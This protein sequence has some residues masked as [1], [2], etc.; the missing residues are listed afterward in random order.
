MSYQTDTD[1]A[2]SFP[3]ILDIPKMS[4]CFSMIESQNQDQ[5]FYSNVTF[6]EMIKRSPPAINILQSCSYRNFTQNSMYHQMNSEMCANIFQITRYKM[7]S[8]LCYRFE[9]DSPSQY[10]YHT[11]VNSLYS[12]R[13]LFTMTINSPL[14]GAKVIYPILHVNSYP[15]ADRAFNRQAFHNENARYY[16]SYSL[17]ESVS[18]PLPYETACID[19]SPLSCF[20]QCIDFSY[21]PRGFMSDS[22]LVLEDTDDSNL[23]LIS[24]NS[25]LDMQSNINRCYKQC[26]FNACK[27]KLVITH[28]SVP[29]QS[30]EKLSFSIQITDQLTQRN[31][32]V[33]K[34]SL[35]DYLTQM[36]GLVG[37]WT[38]ISFTSMIQVITYQS[39]MN[40]FTEIKRKVDD[41]ASKMKQ[42]LKKINSRGG[43]FVEGKS[44]QQRP[45]KVK[46]CNRCKG[47]ITLFFT[48]L[49]IIILSLFLWQMN[50]TLSNYFLY[51]T[52]VTFHYEMNPRVKMI[53][54][55]LCF[56][57][58]DIFN[59]TSNSDVAEKNYEDHFTLINSKSN[60]TLGQM[61]DQLDAVKMIGGCYIRDW[62]S[63]FKEM[64]FKQSTE[65][66][67]HII[68]KKV[69]FSQNVCVSIIPLVSTGKHYQLDYRLLS[70]SPGV[71]ISIDVNVYFAHSNIITFAFFGSGKPTWATEHST[72]IKSDENRQV[73]I[74]TRLHE[75]NILPAP[76]DTHCNKS[77]SMSKCYTSCVD[78]MSEKQ[79]KIAL[80]S[81][82]DQHVNM[83]TLTF[84]D[85][86]NETFYS[87]WTHLERGCNKKCQS[88]SCKYN[89]VTTEL[90]A[91]NP[92]EKHNLL[93]SLETPSYPSSIMRAQ[94]VMLI[95]DLLFQLTS[96]LTF[97]LGFSMKS[98]NPCDLN[99]R[100]QLYRANKL[101]RRKF[102][103]LRRLAF[104]L[105]PLKICIQKN[106]QFK[107]AHLKKLIIFII[108]IIASLACFIHATY[109]IKLYLSYPSYI[110]VFQHLES[111]TDL[112]LFLCL[113]TA[114]LIIGNSSDHLTNEQRS[115]VFS[116]RNI[117]Q[118]LDETPNEDEIIH[119]CSHWGLAERRGKGSHM[120]NVT[121][122]ILFTTEN[123]SICYEMYEVEKMVFSKYM[124]YSVRPRNYTN[125]PSSQMRHTLN[126][127]KTLLEFTIESSLLTSTFSLVVNY[128]PWCPFTS[129]NFGG[130]MIKDDQY[131]HYT[132]S[133]I[134]LY[135]SRLFSPYRYSGFTPFLFDRCV[136]YCINEKLSP[137]N[138][139]MSRRFT[140]TSRHLNVHFVTEDERL[141]NET[142]DMINNLTTTCESGCS[143]YNYYI[144]IENSA[145]FEVLVPLV[146][147]S[148]RQR[149][150]DN[151]IISFELT[152]TRYPVFHIIFKLRMTFFEHLIILGNLLGIWFGFSMMNLMKLEK[153]STLNKVSQDDIFFINYRV[154]FLSVIYKISCDSRFKET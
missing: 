24:I 82:D 121:D 97:W 75:I 89:F 7:Q 77:G 136:N 88:N 87:S 13:Q 93:I 25:T 28:L 1:V 119:S 149:N 144:M 21:R 102:I 18:L 103:R 50:N 26:Q 52:T 153:T 42:I 91:I 80:A 116:S 40:K 143:Y 67:K 85:F 71:M 78:T 79:N 108:W 47:K 105:L 86:S 111:R 151:D 62:K 120:A 106:F 137:L 128:G 127:P 98:L 59:F 8:Y 101:L 11:L 54:L 16:I 124:C 134:R 27:S 29:Y 64:I 63:R 23:R 14:N 69:Y 46:R 12:P 76:Y 72:I 39:E 150:K 45:I 36:A 58:E 100:V 20:Q 96:T 126:R 107:R 33:I 74:S 94:P 145:K 84:T 130:T 148:E 112:S 4:L 146:M 92:H 104:N 31:E 38:G 37:I 15:D 131:N 114:E 66:M 147:P 48:L 3:D 113:D 55:S 41:I 30:I 118:L 44:N 68:L 83:K 135:E 138:I 99:E 117:S 19:W 43:Y 53:S 51:S 35:A 95:Y 61:F 129:S 109:S 139:T 56:S 70:Q 65:C 142:G 125:W 81:I 154:N 17:L 110:D 10:S 6:N 140:R 73:F 133:Y 141:Y 2:P 49:E 57:Y 22:G 32:H 90:A 132:V 60:Y 122:R 34:L 152:P 115:Q 5:I 123:K 9:I